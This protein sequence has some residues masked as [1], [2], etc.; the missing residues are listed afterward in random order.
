M[1]EDPPI[2]NPEGTLPVAAPFGPPIGPLV[3]AKRV[4]LRIEC[5]MIFSVRS[6]IRGPGPSLETGNRN[7]AFWTSNS[8]VFFEFETF[9][10]RRAEKYQVLHPMSTK[11]YCIKKILP[12]SVRQLS[13]FDSSR[14]PVDC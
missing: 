3:S 11:K 2:L 14:L 12:I 7:A 10:P 1:Q 6:P 9:S 13:L 4:F 8:S 5:E